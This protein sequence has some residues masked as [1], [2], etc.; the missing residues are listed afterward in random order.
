MSKARPA[1]TPAKRSPVRAV[2][3]PPADPQPDAQEYSILNATGKAQVMAQRLNALEQ[4]HFGLGLAADEEAAVGNAD[5]AAA[6]TA[7]QGQV[8]QRIAYLRERMAE[9]GITFSAVPA[10]D[11]AAGEQP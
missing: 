9:A 10:D 5:A 1:R 8:A 4:E 7:S 11:E 3:S 6:A 2:P